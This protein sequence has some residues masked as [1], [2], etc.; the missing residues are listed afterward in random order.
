MFGVAILRV[1]YFFGLGM[2]CSEAIWSLS[3]CVAKIM[4]LSSWRMNSRMCSTRQGIA[5]EQCDWCG[6]MFMLVLA[7]ASPVCQILCGLFPVASVFQRPEGK[8]LKGRQRSERL[9]KRNSLTAKRS[10]QT[11]T[12]TGRV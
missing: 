4:A 1:A 6:Y 11:G 8:T 7:G 3:W 10:G 2:L 5:R 9:G 12:S